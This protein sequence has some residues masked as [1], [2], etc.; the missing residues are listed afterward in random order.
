MSFAALRRVAALVAVAG[1]I[2]VF[3]AANL[4]AQDATAWI[5]TFKGPFVS[6]GPTGN[7]TITFAQEDK[8][9][10]VTGEVEAEGAPPGEGTGRD[11]VIEANTFQFAQTYGE[12]DVVFKG[13]LEGTT[14]KGTLEAY[15]GGSMVGSGSF[16]L[17]K[18]T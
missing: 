2:S 8:A 3:G 7:L 13:T 18:Q 10:K 12:Y 6:D 9:W 11:I 16:E 14:L 17:K 4:E 15:Q 5:G 1:T